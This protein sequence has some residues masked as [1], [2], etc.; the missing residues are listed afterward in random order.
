MNIS[1]IG[2][3]MTRFGELW[4]VSLLDLAH[5]AMDQALENSELLPK[6]IDALFVG[7]M[8]SGI[9]NNQANL[10]SLLA[11]HIGTGIP[12][13]YMEGACASGGIALHNAIQ[14]VLSGQNKTVMV[15]GVEKMTDHSGDDI[16]AGLMGA[17]SEAERQAGATF[18]GIYAFMARAYMEQYGVTEEDLAA[19]SVKNHFHGSF[20]KK[21]QFRFTITINDVMKSSKIADP[22]K[23]LDCSPIT[24]GAA[25]II[26]TSKKVSSKKRISITASEVAS[27]TVGL[28]GRSTFTSLSAVVKAAKK[29]YHKA[30]ITPKDIQIA[31]VHDCFSIAEAIAHE[32]LGF[33]SPGQATKDIIEGKRTIGTGNLIVNPSGGLK[34][35]GHPVGATGI[36]QIVEL[37][38]QLRGDAGP[39]QVNNA[40]IGL[41]HNVGGSGTIAVIHILQNNL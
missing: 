41:A 32:D 24:D 38:E 40:K 34:A 10:G 7:N 8:L 26:I 29:A 35:C 36:K 11:E 14:S 22:L 12:A 5:E 21:A 28:S 23:L 18:P 16:T 2:T 37:T 30:K 9:L 6:D 3:G 15:V 19:I 1:I 17:G 20:N 33:S 31:E 27:D 39:R 4:K 13:F 25:A